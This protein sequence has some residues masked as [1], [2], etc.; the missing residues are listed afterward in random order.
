[1]GYEREA[2]REEGF[3]AK[4]D[5]QGRASGHS[6]G[7]SVRTGR[8][9]ADSGIYATRERYARPA[10]GFDIRARQKQISQ[11]LRTAFLALAL[12][13]FAALLGCG[14]EEAAQAPQPAAE[15]TPIDLSDLLMRAG[16]ATAAVDSFHFFLEHSEDASTPY[17]DLGPFEL[18]EAEGDLIKPDKMSLTF[19]GVFSG[20]FAARSSV[21]AVGEESYITNPLTGEWESLTGLLSPTD[22]FDPQGVFVTMLTDV[23]DPVLVSQMDGEYRID[24]V[25][26]ATALQPLLGNAAQG[27]KVNVELTIDAGSLLLLKAVV[28]GQVTLTE[29]ADVVRT[30]TLSRFNDPSIS[31]TLPE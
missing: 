28:K 13:A 25:L 3:Y 6:G 14:G 18:T 27:G 26:E 16:E 31:I 11:G 12:V 29:E 24:G 2:R 23:Q 9:S 5:N 8:R 10:G 30:V 21:I 4:A 7:R 1:M 20:S 22:L 15:P 19:D 17:T